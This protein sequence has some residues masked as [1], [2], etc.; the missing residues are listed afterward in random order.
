MT[1][2]GEKLYDLMLSKGY[3]ENFARIIA[4]QMQTE[5]TSQRMC[6]WLGRAGL[7]P[8]AE[9]ADEMLSILAE[10]DRLVQKHIA[11]HAQK[12]I[13]QLYMEGLSEEDD[14]DEG[15]RA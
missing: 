1:E 5:Y 9:V 14:E 10:R 2:N 8:A 3:P 15:Q 7:L 11:M 6:A 4:E 13:N 12:K